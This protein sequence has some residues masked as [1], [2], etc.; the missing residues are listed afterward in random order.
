M[1]LYCPVGGSPEAFVRRPNEK[2][3]LSMRKR[4]I[5]LHLCRLMARYHALAKAEFVLNPE[6]GR[7]GQPE[8]RR[9]VP[10]ADVA[11]E[12][13]IEMLRGAAREL[14]L[15]KET[16][17]GSAVVVQ[18]QAEWL[19]LAQSSVASHGAA[20]R[21]VDIDMGDAM[22]IAE[23]TKKEILRCVRGRCEGSLQRACAIHVCACVRRRGIG[24]LRIIMTVQTASSWQIALKRQVAKSAFMDAANYIVANAAYKCSRILAQAQLAL[25]NGA[26]AASV[27]AMG[28]LAASKVPL[29]A[30]G[31]RC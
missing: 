31:A 7:F 26:A 3:F 28:F 2:T 22:Q 20:R 27:L 6:M 12:P 18:R 25:A 8:F 13:L 14:K 15:L 11:A 5:K 1:S 10:D 4:I 30:A 19:Q 17:V 9:I 24:S 23:R 16:D 29:G 21:A